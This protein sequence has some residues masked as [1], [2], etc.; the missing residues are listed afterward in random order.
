MYAGPNHTKR[1]IGLYGPMNQPDRLGDGATDEPTTE[2]LRPLLLYY[3]IG[4]Y[5]I[6][7]KLSQIGRG[8]DVKA[9]KSPQH[10]SRTAPS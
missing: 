8:H 10:G 2:T 3:I 6:D 1:L 7:G 5:I 4:R 9:V